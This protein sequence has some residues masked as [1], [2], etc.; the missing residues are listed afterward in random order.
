MA[1]RNGASVTMKIDERSLRSFK[2]NVDALIHAEGKY[3]LYNLKDFCEDV[4]LSANELVPIDTGTLANSASYKVK[5]ESTGVYTARVGY[6]ITRNP[7]NPRTGKSASA[8]AGAVHESYHFTPFPDWDR[9]N[10]NGEGKFLEKALYQHVEDFYR[11]NKVSLQTLLASPQH[12]VTVNAD[13][14]D[15]KKYIQPIE[16]RKNSGFTAQNK[17][18]ILPFPLIGG[19]VTTGR[20]HTKKTAYTERSRVAKRYS[21]SNGTYTER[22]H[23]STQKRVSSRYTNSKKSHR[24]FDWERAKRRGRFMDNF[25]AGW[26]GVDFMRPKYEAE[27]DDDDKKKKKD[28]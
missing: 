6:G 19:S 17:G 2:H 23:T 21:R 1:T 20:K 3:A 4:L 26:D 14:E 13:M 18:E 5:K 12:A 16:V 10:P 24:K 25:A 8:Y 9:H 11:S 15:S 22:A 28:K 7:V 27:K